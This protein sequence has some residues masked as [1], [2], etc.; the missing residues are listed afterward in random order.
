MKKNMLIAVLVIAFFSCTEV[1]DEVQISDED[2]TISSDSANILHGES[3]TIAEGSIALQHNGISFTEEEAKIWRERIN[4]PKFKNESD[5]IKKNARSFLIQPET[6]IWSHPLR[7]VVEQSSSGRDVAI[8]VYQGI[9]LRDAAFYYLLTKDRIYGEKVRDVLLKQVREP[10]VNFTDR[11]IWPLNLGSQPPMFQVAEWVSTLINAFDYTEDVYS[12]EEAAEIKKWFENA[13]IFF[14]ENLN[15]VLDNLFVDRENGD[16]TLSGYTKT[17]NKNHRESHTF[18]THIGGHEIPAIAAWNYQN[19]QAS[20]AR[21]VAKVGFLVENETLIKSARNYVKESV[22]FWA[23]PS[24]LTTEFHRGFDKARPEAGY[25]Y[26]WTTLELLLYIAD[27]F[28]RSGDF[29]LFEFKTS[30]GWFGTAGGEKSL[31]KVATTLCQIK[32]KEFYDPITRSKKI[33]SIASNNDNYLIDGYDPKDFYT[34]TPLVYA[35]E[36]YLAQYNIYFNDPYIKST[37]M[38]ALNTSVRISSSGPHHFDQGVW[39]VNPS[40]ILMYWDL[41]GKVWPFEKNKD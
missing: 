38:K 15:N 1:L 17:L 33:Y 34:Q 14:N 24:G 2:K 3:L 27:L 20:Q 10:S 35:Q 22:M 6:E 21:T 4:S 23:Y 8:P 41:E 16:Y 5:R 13:G 18:L 28:A 32:N 9:K 7:P 37:Y 25:Y 36:I 12:V 39:G 11:S 19:R 40:K 29:S 31:W 30:E 26:S